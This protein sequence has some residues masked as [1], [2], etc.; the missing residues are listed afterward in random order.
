MSQDVSNEVQ[1]SAIKSAADRMG[2][3]LGAVKEKDKL[4]VARAVFDLAAEI[5]VFDTEKLTEMARERLT[6]AR[7]WRFS[8]MAGD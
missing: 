1:L 5:D 2:E 3:I 4:V 8:K 6:P 7:G